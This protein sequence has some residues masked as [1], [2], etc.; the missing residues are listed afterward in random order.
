VNT[1]SILHFIAKCHISF[2]VI[3]CTI[4]EKQKV[5]KDATVAYLRSV[6][7]KILI[8]LS[9]N[10]AHVSTLCIILNCAWYTNA[11]LS[12]DDTTIFISPFLKWIVGMK[13]KVGFVFL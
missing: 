11:A 6:V 12:A 2:H 1:I 13:R 10:T 5:P 3:P 9:A 8:F 7:N 4:G